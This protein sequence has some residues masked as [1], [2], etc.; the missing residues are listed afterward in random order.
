MS[1]LHRALLDETAL[2]RRFI[3][4]LREEQSLLTSGQTDAL[5]EVGATKL[6]LVEK[7]NASEQARLR[8]LGLTPAQ[9][10]RQDMAEWLRRNPAE[11][12]AR[13]SWEQ[14]ITL[15]REAREIHAMNGELIAMHLARTSEALDILTQRQS[16]ASLYGSDGQAATGSGSRIVDSA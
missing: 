2:L 15:A 13:Q 12:A 7:L 1:Q 3:E 8:L 14:L 16:E 6:D 9:S 4:V 10:S 5:A 11:S